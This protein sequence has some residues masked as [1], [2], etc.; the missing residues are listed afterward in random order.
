MR[1]NDPKI[2][3]RRAVLF[4]SRWEGFL[5]QPSD[6]LDGHA[7]IGYGHLIH[8]GPVTEEDRRKW[9][10]I[11]EEEAYWLL[12]GDIRAT[13]REVRRLV[14]V[15]INRRQFSTLISFP[16]NVGIGAFTESTLRRKLNDGAYAAVP[17]ELRRW[18]NFNGHSS[19]GLLNRRN[20]EGRMFRPLHRPNPKFWR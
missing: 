20:A 9:G 18:I 16:F 4:I 12:R 7:T 17:G 10:T 15:P 3:P 6:E 5:P 19:E 13:A 11:T 14:T 2:I 8:L 1:R